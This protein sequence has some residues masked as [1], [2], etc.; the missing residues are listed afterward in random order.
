[1]SQSPL[2][3]SL[4]ESKIAAV[5]ALT[6]GSFLDFVRLCGFDPTAHFRYA[7]WRNLD[8]RGL[9]LRGFDFTGALFYGT[10]FDGALIGPGVDAN[11]IPS[12]AA[13]FD[14]AILG[15]VVW[16]G[17]SAHFSGSVDL[18]VCEDFE[19]YYL[20]WTKSSVKLPRNEFFL[21]GQCFKD[22]PLAPLM[23]TVP[24]L[25]SERNRNF[26]FSINSEVGEALRP[27]GLA[28]SQTCISAESWGFLCESKPRAS[29]SDHNNLFSEEN[30]NVYLR[31]LSEY[32]G[33]TYRLLTTEEADAY[34]YAGY[35]RDNN[36]GR[37]RWTL[38]PW[39]LDS[40]V[41]L[42]TDA[43]RQRLEEISYARIEN[44]KAGY[45][46]ATRE[47]VGGEIT[48]DSVLEKK[49]KAAFRV[50]RELGG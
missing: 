9:N 42:R 48:S 46:N 44:V 34:V 5:Q 43:E 17:K 36:V 19:Q 45:Y 47:L 24:P 18:S 49:K 14:S 20:S 22:G 8:F 13:R 28:I 38:N 40:A 30:I 23:I 37:G 27:A 15:Q 33:A 35:R 11:G 4:S 32:S 1:M 12:S 6:A 50:I 25:S 3:T 39:C 41:L 7:D 31:A 16:R 29:H 21:E 26:E 2:V 10:T